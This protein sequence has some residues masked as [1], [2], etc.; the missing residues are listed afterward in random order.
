MPMSPVA[1]PLLLGPEKVVGT[2][3]RF[4]ASGSAPIGWLDTVHNHSGKWSWCRTES[5]R[6][7]PLPRTP[8]AK[9]ATPSKGGTASLRGRPNSGVFS[10]ASGMR[11]SPRPRIALTSYR[12]SLLLCNFASGTSSL[13]ETRTW[14]GTC[15]TGEHMHP[16]NSTASAK[17][18]GTPQRW[19]VVAGSNAEE[20]SAA[21]CAE[22]PKDGSEG[23]SPRGFAPLCRSYAWPLASKPRRP[24]CR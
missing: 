9:S 24:R 21:R 17:T 2:A 13:G 1:R 6:T 3:S 20:G 7:E 4:G 19:L 5:S 18:C 14:H 15:G 22:P 16:K 23:P 10:F 11:G 8:P 12:Q